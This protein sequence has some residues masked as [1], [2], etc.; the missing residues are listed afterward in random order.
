MMFVILGATGDLTKKKL[1]PS[2]YNLILKGKVKQISIVGVSFEQ[3][4]AEAV[5]NR[6]KK[7]I[8]NIDS[9]IWNKLKKNFYY[10]QA[11]FYDQK[12]FAGLGKFVKSIEKNKSQRIFYLATL[13]QHFKVVADN[14]AKCKLVKKDSRVVFEKPFGHNLKSAKEINRCIK[15]VFTEKQIYRIDHYLGKELIQNIAVARFT[16]TI[17]E[18]LWSNKYVDHIQIILSEDVG[19]EERGAFYDKYGVIRDVVQNHMMQMLSL[20]TMESPKKLTGD[21]IRDEKVKILKKVKVKGKATVGQYIGYTNEK[22]IPKNS[23]TETFAALKLEIDNPRWK[24]VPFYLIAGKKMK[25]KITSIY[26]Q[27]KESPCL[28]FTGVCNFMPNYLVIQIQPQEGF[29][30]QMNAKVPGKTDIKAVKLDFCHECTFGPNSPEA[31]ENLF[32]D[33]I[34]GDQSSFVRTDEIEQQWK[35]VD[36]IKKGKLIKYKIGTHPKEADK[37]N[38]HLQVK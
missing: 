24:G 35:I 17:L 7:Y 6:S 20:S 37:I 34:K 23:K 15:K 8:K 38:W 1:I 29:Y 18:P 11:D 25:D 2:I 19:I 30:I 9:K 26:V 12:K 31:Y 27:F 32:M 21:Y 33:V 4:E 28:L 5:L 16:N 14:L 3:A 22:K 13:P 36:S 10:Y